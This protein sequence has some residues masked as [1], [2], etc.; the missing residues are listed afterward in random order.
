MALPQKEDIVLE[1]AG[2]SEFDDHAL[3][4]LQ[5]VYEK[6]VECVA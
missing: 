4:N 6:V 5:W 2:K 3:Q 1:S